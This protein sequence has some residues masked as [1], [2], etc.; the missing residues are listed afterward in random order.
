[1]RNGW[2]QE[3]RE[4]ERKSRK[5]WKG[6]L[7]DSLNP[8][9]ICDMIQTEVQRHGDDCQPHQLGQT[10]KR[11]WELKQLFKILSKERQQCVTRA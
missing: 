6:N 7:K 1:M 5:K 4:G 2:N 10:Q 8:R 11:K 9:S 3:S